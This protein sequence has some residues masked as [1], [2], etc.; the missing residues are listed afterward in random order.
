[1]VVYVLIE[2]KGLEYIERAG[3]SDLSWDGGFVLENWQK[4]SG[5]DDRINVHDGH[6]PVPVVIVVRFE[7][8]QSVVWV[9][10]SERLA[11][12]MDECTFE[13]L[14]PKHEREKQVY[15]RDVKTSYSC[16]IR[17][18]FEENTIPAGRCDAT[19]F[20]LW[21]TPDR[22]TVQSPNAGRVAWSTEDG[23][24][25]VEDRDILN[26]FDDRTGRDGRCSGEGGI[27]L[28]E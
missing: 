21:G 17:P 24:G 23:L 10:I 12:F 7:D 14:L 6:D 11:E 4:M 16:R 5:A 15:P 13:H 27:L 22:F 1:V 2:V 19:R 9:W 20:P 3:E 26:G 28:V 8:P 25:G 18:G